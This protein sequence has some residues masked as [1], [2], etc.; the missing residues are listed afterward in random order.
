M[1]W[2]ANHKRVE[3]DLD[4]LGGTEG[5]AE[6]GPKR[7]RYV[8]QRRVVCASATAAHRN[9][10]Y[11]GPMDFV[12]D[13]D[14]IDGRSDKAADRSVD[15]VQSRECLAI[16]GGRGAWESVDVIETHWPG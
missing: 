7:S 13:E 2:K 8:A 12:F 15:R 3:Q 14:C 11:A 9:L 16:Q 4:R 1:G 5:A 10:T 6:T